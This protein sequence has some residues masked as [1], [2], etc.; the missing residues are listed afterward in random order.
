MVIILRGSVFDTNKVVTK[1]DIDSKVE[2]KISLNEVRSLAFDA[3]RI[4]FRKS[5]DMEEVKDSPKYS[6]MS[7]ERS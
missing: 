7:S 3:Y 2:S 4:A 5:S 6:L 1:E